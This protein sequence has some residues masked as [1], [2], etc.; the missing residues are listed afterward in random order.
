LVDSDS[1]RSVEIGVI[2][3]RVVEFVA[4]DILA[5]K[6]PSVDLAKKI[7]ELGDRGIAPWIRGYM[8]TLRILGNESVHEKTS[9]GRIPAHVNQDDLALCLF[10]L[11]RV[12]EFWKAFKTPAANA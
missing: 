5:H 6:R 12:V 9:D 7:D 1:T 8:H 4:D 11:Q 2:G 10:C 3:R